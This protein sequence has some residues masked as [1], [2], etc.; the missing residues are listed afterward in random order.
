MIVEWLAMHAQQQ[1]VLEKLQQLVA[2][3]INQP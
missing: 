3:P 2:P 1:N